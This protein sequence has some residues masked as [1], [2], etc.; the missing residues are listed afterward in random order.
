[1]E[2][3]FEVQAEG[4]TLEKARWLEELF[5]SDRVCL[6]NRP[7]GEEDYLDEMFPEVLITDST[8]EAQDGDEELNKVKFTYRHVSSRP[9]SRIVK[10]DRIHTDQFKNPFN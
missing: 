9:D 1:M 5:A 3:T 6:L 10:R 7:Y 2:Q 8:S 4:L